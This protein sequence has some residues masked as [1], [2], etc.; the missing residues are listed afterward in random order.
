[1]KQ[2][3]LSLIKSI[4]KNIIKMGKKFLDNLKYKK[5]RELEPFTIISNNCIAG[6]LYQGFSIKYYSPTVGLQFSQDDF[7]KFCSDFWDYMNCEL[8]ES[9]NK[10]QEIFTSL[11]GGEI[12]F[13]VGKINDIIIYFQHYKTFEYAKQKW[14]ERKLRI[15]RDK[16]FF[17]FVAYNNTSIE[18][19][20]RFESI[21][22]KNKLIIT[23][24][25]IYISPISF[26]LHN[27]KNPWY[28]RT[29]K[30]ISSKRYYEKYNFYDWIIKNCNRK[31]GT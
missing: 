4:L 24:D 26:A 25:P 3:S 18:T 21:P 1:M 20:K 29:N 7:V 8:E 17:V 23:N 10:N 14:N 6:F 12:D 2:Y 9:E 27:G 16:L 19:I 30:K 11:G 13:P 28:E 22:F 5:L 15:N 31:N